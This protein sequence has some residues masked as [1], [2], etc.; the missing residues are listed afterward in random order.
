MKTRPVRCRS[1]PPAI[2]LLAIGTLVVLLPARMA[3]SQEVA[4]EKTRT[5]V[6]ELEDR[7]VSELARTWFR[8]VEGVA[9]DPGFLESPEGQALLM[10]CEALQMIYHQMRET[11]KPD[12]GRQGPQEP[13]RFQFVDWLDPGLRYRVFDTTTGEIQVREARPAEE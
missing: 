7:L 4:A 12:R 8:V 11:L 10:Q 6:E 3:M 1:I 13:G 2:A 9:D 5:L